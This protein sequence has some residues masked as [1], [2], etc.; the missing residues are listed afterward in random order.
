MIQNS[1]VDHTL[2][3]VRTVYMYF[4]LIQNLNIKYTTTL[5]SSKPIRLSYQLVFSLMITNTLTIIILI[6]FLS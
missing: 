3:T 4:L 2:Y 5:L 6:I 1:K